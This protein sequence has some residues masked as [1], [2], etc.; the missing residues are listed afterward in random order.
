MAEER[1]PLG[2]WQIVQA[3]PEEVRVAKRLWKKKALFLADECLSMGPELC[4]YLRNCGWNIKHVN[5]V[6]LVGRPD[7]DVLAFA[8]R[9]KRIILTH[10]GKHFL[11]L[12]RHPPSRHPGVVAV[13]GA[14][15]E[16]DAYA[17]AINQVLG[18]I[19]PFAGV[20]NNTFVNIEKGG[21]WNVTLV[22][23]TG[24]RKRYRLRFPEN[25]PPED[26]I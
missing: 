25:R 21:I 5:E 14:N 11:D 22:D 18:Y 10:N 3:T 13:P 20:W 23:F 1:R 19:G 17:S 7:E 4:L 2:R 8:W 15:G 9:E 16:I 12:R 6:G 26:G 24:A